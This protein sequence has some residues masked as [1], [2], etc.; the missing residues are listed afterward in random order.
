MGLYLGIDL[1]TTKIAAVL[2]DS[3]AGRIKKVISQPHRALKISGVFRE[4]DVR[5]TLDLSLDIIG[6]LSSRQEIS[7]L[8]I[9]SQ[10]HGCLLVDG[11]NRP[12]SGLISWQDQRCL[13]P[14][15]GKPGRNYLEQILAKAGPES[16]RDTG[17]TISAGFLGPTLFWLSQ[18][19]KLPAGVKACFIG[20]YLASVL[21]GEPVSPD[22]T[23]AG[24]S[25]FYDIRRKTWLWPVIKKLNLPPDLFPAV[26][27]PGSILGYLKT[28]FSG[29]TVRR[30]N[31][32][33]FRAVGDNQASVLGS[34]GHLHKTLLL[35]IGTGS[36]ISVRSEKF[37]RIPGLDTRYF[38][39]NSYLL[40]G[41]GLSGGKTLALAERFFAEAGL[42]LFGRKSNRLYQKMSRLAEEQLFRPDRM[43]C[44][45]FFSGTRNNPDRTG[46]LADIRESNFH[47]AD[48]IF[49]LMEG[50]IFEL[51]SFAERMP[52][53]DVRHVVGAGNAVRK[54]PLLGAIAANLFNRDFIVNRTGEEAALGACFLAAGRLE[55][56]FA[57]E[58]TLAGSGYDCPVRP[59]RQKTAICRERYRRFRE[60]TQR[61]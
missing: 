51:Y 27:E 38:L 1:G 2:Y 9:S 39:D 54:N 31:I 45:P 58:E 50:I 10:M 46:F 44:G 60:L 34:A 53:T 13:A 15:P 47:P 7:A 36:Q 40:V 6:R 17:T 8:G 32:P 57:P 24:S 52:K 43:F 49:G 19:K 56:S 3:G 59:D 18:N 11:K 28:A 29:K 4:I 37:R 25:G 21:T 48:F 12:A 26:E 35:N 20:D 55:K 23:C 41:A 42:E 14:F 16:F 30:Q 33:V 61:F 5:K 22:I